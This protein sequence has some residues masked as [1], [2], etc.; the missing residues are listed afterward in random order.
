MRKNVAIDSQL[1]NLTT[2][3]FKRQKT[4]E[5]L[6]K[7]YL[8]SSKKPAKLTILTK[9]IVKLG[10]ICKR[11]EEMKSKN[12]KCLK[13]FSKYEES[14]SNESWQSAFMHVDTTQ[15][16]VK[17]IGSSKKPLKEFKRPKSATVYYHENTFHHLQGVQKTSELHRP[18]EGKQLN[19]VA[20]NQ[21]LKRL[22]RKSEKPP[23]FSQIREKTSML[24]SGKGSPSC[25][26]TSI[27]H[28]KE[29]LTKKLSTSF[30]KDNNLNLSLLNKSLSAMSKEQLFTLKEAIDCKIRSIHEPKETDSDS[31]FEVRLAEGSPKELDHPRL[32]GK[33]QLIRIEG[34]K[35]NLQPKGKIK[36][37]EESIPLMLDNSKI[38]SYR[39]QSILESQSEAAIREHLLR[40]YGSFVK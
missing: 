10:Q 3:I 24:S 16:K 1:L 12:L 22:L 5:K 18:I 32:E 38:H 27:Y 20:M 17:T 11:I 37:I 19:L 28:P 33:G 15:S 39:E 29:S 21:N 13:T 36:Q 34:L 31:T 14:P 2:E 30:N 9:P 6:H 40:C 25:N 35:N 26:L 8:A 7:A 23:T 4:K